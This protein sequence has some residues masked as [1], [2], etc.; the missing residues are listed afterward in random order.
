M[1]NWREKTLKLVD[2]HHWKARPGNQVLVLDWGA[3]S[4]EYPETWHVVP[5][6]TVKLYD[7]APPDDEA[8]LQIT[9][10]HLTARVDW[11]GLNFE[12]MEGR[13]FQ[14]DDGDREDLWRSP[15][16]REKRNGIRQAIV[17][18]R[19][20]DSEEQREAYTRQCLARHPN[21]LALLTLDCWIDDK[22]RTDPVWQ[23]ILETMRLGERIEDPRTGQRL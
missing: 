15:L 20:I 19:W 13:L 21:V 10:F 11:S 5:G 17:Q 4:I 18:S 9:L 22:A 3:F 1:S 7:A 2:G 23:A 12:E 8:C 14:P 16:K 6:D